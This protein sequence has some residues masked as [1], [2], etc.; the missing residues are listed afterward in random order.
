MNP[1]LLIGLAVGGIYLLTRKSSPSVTTR[2]V[3]VATDGLKHLSNDELIT[4]ARIAAKNSN[5]YI[6]IAIEYAKKHTRAEVEKQFPE[7]QRHEDLAKVFSAEF[8]RRKLTVPA[9]ILALYANA[10]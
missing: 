10:G 2:D 8:S 9:D 5:Q 3:Q 6:A 4:A 7:I 1:L